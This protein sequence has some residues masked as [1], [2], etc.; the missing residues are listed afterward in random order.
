MSGSSI[1][2]K[3]SSIIL[4]DL[5]HLLQRLQSDLLFLPEMRHQQRQILLFHLHSA[6][7]QNQ[8][9]VC[10]VHPTLLVLV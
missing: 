8:L 1:G 9:Q 6:S 3:A 5:Q 4:L 7:L 10:L 2:I